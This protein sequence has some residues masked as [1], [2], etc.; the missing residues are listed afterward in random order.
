[1]RSPAVRVCTLAPRTLAF[2]L[3]LAAGAQTVLAQPVF[4]VTRLVTEEDFVAE[5]GG[6]V[7][8]INAVAVNDAGTWLAEVDTDGDP[9]FDVVVMRSGSVIL[10]EGQFLTGLAAG[11]LSSVDGFSITAAG[12]LGSNYFLRET[13]GLGNDSGLFFNGTMILQEGTV[14][15]AAAFTAGTPYIGFFDARMNDNNRLLVIASIDDPQI[16]SSVDRAVVTIQYDPGTG[17][18]TEN[19]I[20][21]EGDTLIFQDEAVADFGTGPHT[22]AQNNTGDV[23]YFADLTGNSSFDGAFYLNT[24]TLLAQEGNPSLISGR[25]YSSLASRPIHINE[26]GDVVFR[27]G[28]DGDAATSEVLVRRFAGQAPAVFA[29]EGD[30]LPALAPHAISGF[31]SGPVYITGSGDV[32]WIADTDNP[33]TADV[34]LMLNGTPVLVEGQ[35]IDGETVTS[36]NTGEH[37]FSVSPAG[38]QI[39]V[40]AVISN[41]FGDYNTVLLIDVVCP[42]DFNG[43]G[44]INGDDFDEFV[45]LFEAGDPA[46]DVNGDTFV[47]GEDFDYFADHFVAGC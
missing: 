39:I 11:A 9:D 18:Y 34:A 31:G 38:N 5:T 47:T 12:D 37:G 26:S 21:K 14:S 16:A 2:A 4:T 13:G 42:A 1:M 10:Q 33:D 8:A 30:T 43:D 45:V 29:Q 44:F 35:V 40:R 41:A 15:S 32:V 7:T 46:A 22:Y 19:V 24:G 3:G 23:V 6:F 36:I 17:N 28:L 25:N 20:A 27:A